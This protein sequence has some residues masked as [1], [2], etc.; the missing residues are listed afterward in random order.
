LEA[1]IIQMMNT[2]FGGVFL[3]A[4]SCMSITSSPSFQDLI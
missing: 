3:S 2:N 4:V 1:N